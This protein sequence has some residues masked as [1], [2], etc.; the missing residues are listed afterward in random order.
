MSFRTIDDLKQDFI[1]VCK[2]EN[3][4]TNFALTNLLFLF[5]TNESSV[6]TLAL[7]KGTFSA[8]KICYGDVQ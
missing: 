5:L 6:K 7:S 2:R 3:I 1:E 8:L 4:D